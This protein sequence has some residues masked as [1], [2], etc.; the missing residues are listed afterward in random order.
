MGKSS[1][2]IAQEYAARGWAPIPIP[3]RQKSPTA[4]GW[5]SL[6][7]SAPEQLLEHFGSDPLNIGILLGEPSS[8]LVDIDIDVHEAL[9]FAD[10]F[11]P[12]SAVFGRSGKRDSHRL[13]FCPTETKKFG[14]K[15]EKQAVSLIE[16]RSTGCQT[17]F[18]GSIHE[19]GEQ[20]QWSSDVVPVS[21]DAET[22]ISQASWIAAGALLA[23]EWPR[24][25][26]NSRNA[27]Y[28]AL[29]GGMLNCGWEQD[30]TKRF[31]ACLCDVTEDPDKHDR[32]LIVKAT[33]EK[34]KR[35]KKYT[36]WKTLAEHLNKDVVIR[37]REWLDLEVTSGA[38]FDLTDL[39][40]A[41]RLETIIR[42]SHSH[43]S[44][45]GDLSLW[46]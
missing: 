22:L 44:D 2:Q 4:V 1:Y 9:P 35:E 45:S 25:R 12:N 20:I 10:A 39:G 33:F 21:A 43:N 42:E 19:C 24:E 14:Y 15:R 41:K 30:Y 23:R 7:L 27:M 17:V 28:M 13:Y 46:E 31:I 38:E 8:N 34:G 5:N 26:G 36:G 18:P 40:T 37:A 11:L 16:I 32:L 6:R 3:T 29:I